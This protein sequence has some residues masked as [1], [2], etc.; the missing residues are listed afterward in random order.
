MLHIRSSV[1]GVFLLENEGVPVSLTTDFGEN[2]KQGSLCVDTISNDLYILKGTN[3]T[4]VSLGGTSGEIDLTYVRQEPTKVTI[5]GLASGTVPNFETLQGVF[6]AIL[7]PFQEPSVSISGGSLYEKGLEVF[8]NYPFSVNLQDG[9][10]DTRSIELNSTEVFQPLANNGSYSGSQG[11]TWQ[12]ATPSTYYRH[13]YTYRVTFTNTTVKT[14]S[15][16][17]EF[18]P[19]TYHGVLNELDINET[20]V[21]ALTKRIRKESNDNNLSFSPTLQRYIYAYPVAYGNL[22]RIVDPNGF[23]VTASFKKQVITFTL[24]D[25]TTE[26]YNVYYSDTDTTQVNFEIDFEY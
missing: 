13:T 19:P 24:A 26:D 21:K 25:A 8:G 17:I 1:K 2:I 10:V 15:T 5:G 22:T 7:Y 4:L 9:I 3:W 20:N 14:N 11:L 18:A 23:D 6:D 12:N 16:N